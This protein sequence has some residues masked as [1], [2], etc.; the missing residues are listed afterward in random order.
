MSRRAIVDL[1]VASFDSSDVDSERQFVSIRFLKGWKCVFSD[2]FP[3]P[4][5]AAL[6]V[7]VSFIFRSLRPIPHLFLAEGTL[8][9]G[10]LHVMRCRVVSCRVAVCYSTAVS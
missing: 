8:F 10:A 6:L 7:V 5:G 1:V 3:A 2:V 9:L 4:P